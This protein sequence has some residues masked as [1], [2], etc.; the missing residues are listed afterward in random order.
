MGCCPSFHGIDL[1]PHTGYSGNE[2]EKS[3]ERNEKSI[4]LG[5]SD[6]SEMSTR[7]SDD[8]P[9]DFDRMLEELERRKPR[10]PSPEPPKFSFRRQDRIVFRD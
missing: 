5:V 8:P 1:L 2:N 9:P 10:P 4:E 3:D 7:A 6:S